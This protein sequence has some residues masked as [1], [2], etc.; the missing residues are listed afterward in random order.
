MSP[1]VPLTPPFLP[2]ASPSHPHPFGKGRGGGS[3]ILASEGAGA[4][5]DEPTSLNRGEGLMAG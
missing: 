1:F 5:L 3:C 4:I 2:Q